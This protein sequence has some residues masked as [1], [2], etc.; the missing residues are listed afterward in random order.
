M[1]NV[2]KQPCDEELIRSQETSSPCAPNAG[3]WVLA[4][5]ILGSSMAFIDETAITVALP[6]IQGALDATAVDAQWVVEAATLLLAA[7]VLI[8]GSLGD[9][10]GRRRVFA[11]GVGLFAAASMLGGLAQSPEQLILA[12]AI[13]GVGGALL[14]PNSLAIIGASFEEERR[15]KAIGTWAG[16]TAI[17]MVLGPVL[18]GYLVETVSWRA[19]FFINVPLALAVLAI[20]L[21]RVP[22]SRNGEARR[23]DLPGAA[24]VAAGLGGLVFGLLESSRVGLGNPLV[25]GSLILGVTSLAAF[26]VVEGWSR[27]P[28][29]PLGLFR[30]RNF[31]GANVFTLLLYF[32]LSGTLFFLPFNLI[33]VQGYS[34]TAAGAA[35]L[36]TIVL[37]FILSRYTGG[38]T[39]R[40]GPRIPLVLGPAIAAAGF[41]LFA[42]PRIGGSYWTTFFPAAVVLGVGLAV[43][44]PAV[45]TVALNSVDTR[46]SGLASAINNAFSQ[47][48]GL[49]AI[50]VL[51]VL[52]F[53]AFGGSLD[54]RLTTLE[55]PSEARQQLEQEKIKLGAAEAPEGIGAGLEAAVERSVDEA[56]V[57]GYRTVMLVAAAMALASAVSAAL[58]IQGG[59]PK[60]GQANEKVREEDLEILTT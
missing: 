5:T 33:W 46:R 11:V 20:T 18:G 7:L 54:S 6:A 55:L 59:K 57:S 60:K 2:I 17:T 23:L 37:M 13:Q 43:L 9:H 28:M 47:T 56:F 49:L 4:A 31:T 51:G 40:F 58:L 27:E 35:V 14:V 15:G 44:V 21:Y 52:M 24:L 16:F 25:I 39:N 12:R 30:S 38:L 36:P 8:G 48:A 32:A 1:A 50:A 45:T 42:V 10:L 19:V 29:M 53:A 34:A 26:I 41:A 22:E 3:P